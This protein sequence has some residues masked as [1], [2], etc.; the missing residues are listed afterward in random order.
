MTLVD[1]AGQLGV[2]P[3]DVAD[4]LEHL[5]KSLEH[6]DY[7]A[8]VTPARCRK[9]ELTFDERKLRKPSKCPACRS[10]WIEAPLV[11]VRERRAR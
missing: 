2:S 4:D 6:S 10:T 7:V 8:I 3:R 11:E 1:I 5:L 9:C